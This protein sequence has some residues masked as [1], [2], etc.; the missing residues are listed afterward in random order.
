VLK[1]INANGSNIWGRNTLKIMIEAI[2][3]RRVGDKEFIHINAY[4]NIVLRKES[5][6]KWIHKFNALLFVKI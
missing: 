3:F 4:N 1:Y 6:Y 5:T 2:K